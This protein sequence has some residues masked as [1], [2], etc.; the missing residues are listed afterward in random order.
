MPTT[1]FTIRAETSAAID[2]QL[3]S[4]ND[5]DG[6]AESGINLTGVHHL[7]MYLVNT[8]TAGTATYSTTDSSPK[9]AIT[10]AAAGSVSFTPSGTVD[11][12]LRTNGESNIYNGW[13]WVFATAN[14]KFA[15]PENFEFTIRVR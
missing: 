11:M 4:D 15:V 13:W 7:E 12:P 10:N 1:D 5:G 14:T 3:L 2:M 6:V 9:I 8:D